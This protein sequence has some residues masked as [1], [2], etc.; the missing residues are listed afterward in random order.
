MR[1]SF[2]SSEASAFVGYTCSKASTREARVLNSMLSTFVA[3][4]GTIGFRVD[5]TQ[6]SL[7]T[8]ASKSILVALKLQSRSKETQASLARSRS[9]STWR[10]VLAR[11]CS[12]MANCL[13]NASSPALALASLAFTSKVKVMRRSETTLTL[14]QYSFRVSSS[15]KARTCLSK[16][17]C[18]RISIACMSA[19]LALVAANSR[20]ESKRSPKETNSWATTLR[21]VSMVCFTAST[22]ASRRAVS[23]SMRCA[24]V[25]VASTARS[26]SETAWLVTSAN[27]LV[28]SFMKVASSAFVA[29]KSFA[30]ASE[31][32][33][34]LEISLFLST[35]SSLIDRISLVISSKKPWTICLK[36]SES[37]LIWATFSAASR[38]KVPT[39]AARSPSNLCCKAL[40]SPPRSLASRVISAFK[41]V[42]TSLRPVT[43]SWSFFK[44]FS[45][46][47]MYSMPTSAMVTTTLLW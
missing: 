4:V 15:F 18:M 13:A 45:V 10:F 36:L 5:S 17:S 26:R 38:R 16:L 27:W 31:V 11:L 34:N 44:S 22:K 43:S 35:I 25:R 8:E 23:S 7:T 40:T 9:A 37:A 29:A 33:T 1:W 47:L 6:V 3:R 20:T 39:S 24:T 30:V 21:W 41:R 12:T 2:G 42:H 46:D 14:E 19:S 28:V 32:W